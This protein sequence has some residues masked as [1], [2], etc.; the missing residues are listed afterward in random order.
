MNNPLFVSVV[1]VTRNRSVIL[2][3]CLHSVFAQDYADMEVIVID[4]DST[5]ETAQMLKNTYPSVI[6]LHQQNNTGAPEGRNIGVHKA[7]GDICIFIDDDAE[8]T[9]NQSIRK[10]TEYFLKNSN[11]ACLSMRIVD[12]DNKIVRKLIPRRDRKVITEDTPGALFVTTG[13]ALRRTAFMDA[14]EFWEDL[15]PYFGEEPELSYRLLDKGYNILL[16]PH[17]IVRHYEEKLERHPGRR[18]YFG[19]RNA[20]W[21]ILR[22]LPWYSVIGLTTLAWGY[23]FLIATRDR[24]LPMYFKAVFDSIKHMSAVYRIRKPIGPHAVAML[25]KHSGL[26]LF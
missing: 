1:I 10:S 24:Q 15:N 6:V 17:I 19:T 4:N 12:Q 23:F 11:L 13:C 16:T 14:G 21:F 2:S 18:M 3:R 20:P 9:D 5:D 25:W 22:N 8:F 7:K 26:I